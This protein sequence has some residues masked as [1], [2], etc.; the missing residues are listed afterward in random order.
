M[1]KVLHAT[2]LFLTVIVYWRHEV[3][4]TSSLELEVTMY[5][6]GDMCTRSYALDMTFTPINASSYTT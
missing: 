4:Y 5:I 1:P 2:S 6:K 3:T